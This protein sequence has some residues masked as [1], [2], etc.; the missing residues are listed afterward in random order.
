MLILQAIERGI[1]FEI[2]YSHALRDKSMRKHLISNASKLVFWCKG[3]VRVLG[4]KESTVNL[5]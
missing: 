5:S 1:H 4:F 3:K 2:Q